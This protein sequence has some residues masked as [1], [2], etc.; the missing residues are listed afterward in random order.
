MF[1]LQ[2]HPLKKKKRIYFSNRAK[3]YFILPGMII[4]LSTLV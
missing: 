2:K 3:F 4:E 1:E